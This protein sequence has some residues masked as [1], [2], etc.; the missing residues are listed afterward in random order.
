M[1]LGA[2]LY[3][4]Y[5]GTVRRLLCYADSQALEVFVGIYFLHV[6]LFAGG[7]WQVLV[8]GAL[9]LVASGLDRDCHRA[10]HWASGLSFFAAVFLPTIHE[11]VLFNLV[12]AWTWYRTLLDDKIEK[13]VS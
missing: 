12:S 10:R 4:C 6:G 13:R 9:Q 5:P 2:C 3:S 1:P 7:S 8:A 11:R